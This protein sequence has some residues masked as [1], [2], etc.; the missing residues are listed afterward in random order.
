VEIN[1]TE[2]ITNSPQHE[3]TKTL[4]AATPEIVE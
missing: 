4:L 2:Q 1:S 3:Y